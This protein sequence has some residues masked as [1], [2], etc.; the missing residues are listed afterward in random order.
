MTEEIDWSRPF[1]KGDMKYKLLEESSFKVLFPH[2]REKYLTDNWKKIQD[3]MDSYGINIEVDYKNGNISLKT[4]DKTWD[5]V[6]ILNARDAIK[7]VARSVPIEQAFRVF[8]EGTESNIIIIGKHIRNQERFNKRRQR[9][10]GPGGSTLKAL[11]LLTQCYILVQGHTVSIIGNIR[12]INDASK[13]VVD[14]MN[15][16]HPVYHIKRLMVKRDLMKNPAMANEDWDRYLPKVVKATK[17]TEKKKKVHN[18]RNRG[19]PDYPQDT[20]VDK[21]IESGEY[22]L[23]KKNSNKKKAKNIAEKATQEAKEEAKMPAK[24]IKIRTVSEAAA[25]EK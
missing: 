11:E 12:G 20:E 24:E 22:F 18:E 16:I 8:E 21:Q 4:T 17:H 15:N 7:L 2:Y 25:E 13:V 19:L 3:K 14:C 5:P 10:L 6:A 1:Q 23:K 9:L